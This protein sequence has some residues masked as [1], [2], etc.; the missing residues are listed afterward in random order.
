MV[1]GPDVLDWPGTRRSRAPIRPGSVE[2]YVAWASR[3]SEQGRLLRRV[4]TTT[5]HADRPSR[6]RRALVRVRLLCR[7]SSRSG[8]HDPAGSGGTVSA[9]WWCS[10]A[11]PASGR[12]LTAGRRWAAAVPRSSMG[13]RRRWCWLIPASTFTWRP[14]RRPRSWLPMLPPRPPAGRSCSSPGTSTSRPAAR[15]SP[16]APST[17][18]TCRPTEAAWQDSSSW[19]SSRRAATGPATP[20]QARHRGSSG[21]GLSRRALLLP[22]PATGGLGFR[23][24]LHARPF[25]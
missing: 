4:L 24:G 22:V 16:S 23:P 14:S 19:R 20:P 2:G 11:R 18:M 21:R 10:K 15:A 9:R 5:V 8:R 13:R 6:R 12:A 1:P 25:S 3:P 7:A 17:S